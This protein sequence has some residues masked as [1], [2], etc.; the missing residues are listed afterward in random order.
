[1]IITAVEVNLPIISPAT[2]ATLNYG[3]KKMTDKNRTLNTAVNFINIMRENKSALT[4]LIMTAD[5]EGPLK[6]WQRFLQQEIKRRM[7]LQCY[8]QKVIHESA[9]NKMKKAQPEPG[10]S[11]SGTPRMHWPVCGLFS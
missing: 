10:G 11:R 7:A 6:L 4:S 9:L 3:R 5:D 2:M 8:S 1:M